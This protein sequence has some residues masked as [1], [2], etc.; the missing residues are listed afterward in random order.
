MEGWSDLPT[1]P[2]QV[3]ETVTL[4]LSNDQPELLGEQRENFQVA[5][6]NSTVCY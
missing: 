1:S 2:W 5:S 6:G 4:Q 3:N